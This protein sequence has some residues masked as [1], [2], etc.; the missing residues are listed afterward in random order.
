MNDFQRFGDASAFAIDIRFLPEANGGEGT[1]AASAGS[2]SEWRIWIANINLSRLQFITE[3]GP[4]E[5]DWT[6]WYL[7]PLLHWLVQNWIPLLHETR[8]PGGARRASEL[9]PRWARGAYLSVQE[10]AGDDLRRFEPWQSWAQRHALR[11]AAEGG[12]LPD[13]FF[14]RIGDEM[15]FSW[16]DRIE[17]GNEAAAFLTEDGVAHCSVNAFATALS[18]LIDFSLA[19]SEIASQ[20]WQPSLA[21]Q[22]TALA[23]PAT[24]GTAIA[25]Y[26]DARPSPGDLS[27]K[28]LRATQSLGI[29]MAANDNERWIGELSP[30]VAMFGDL[31]PKI[32]QAAATT[33]IVE[34][35]NARSGDRATVHA[36]GFDEGE[37][38]WAVSS[39]WDNGYVLALDLLDE[40]DPAPTAPK[41]QLER[42]L[43]NLGVRWKSVRLGEFGPRGVAMAGPDVVP[44][45][46]VNQ[47][48]IANAGRGIRFTLAHELCHILFDREKAKTLLHPSTPW[49]P[50]S[51]EQRAN[52]FAAMLLM[53]RHRARLGRHRTVE[54]LKAE[55]DRLADTLG[56]SRS[57]LRH[58]LFNI[59]EIGPQQFYQLTRGGAG[60]L[61]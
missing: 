40:A 12:I 9:A 39:T 7:A 43:L 14:Q 2:W 42:L 52:A 22:W 61:H 50:P 3:E 19:R 29:A 31:S 44:T 28:L 47:D 59:D 6:R 54:A 57:A 49:A 18:D 21:A 30:Q 32:S 53:P 16:G 48:H 1:P 56:V 8:L 41:T 35:F 4:L 33:L 55:I 25:W 11:S 23:G 51:V 45:I 60:G 36:D 24:E 10:T 15:E 13:I 20:P 34:Y 5:R 26:L 46:L 27:K 58:H 38:A 37:P 17:P